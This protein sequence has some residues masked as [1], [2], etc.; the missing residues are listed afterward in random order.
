MDDRDKQLGEIRDKI[1][2]MKKYLQAGGSPSFCVKELIETITLLLKVIEQT[3]E[4]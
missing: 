4:E 3:Q 2:N 1:A